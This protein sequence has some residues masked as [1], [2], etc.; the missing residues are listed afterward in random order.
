MIA[1]YLTA[2]SVCTVLVSLWMLIMAC[3]RS[4]VGK[5][6]NVDDCG[7]RHECVG[8]CAMASVVRCENRQRDSDGTPVPNS[9]NLKGN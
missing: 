7:D 1:T 2:V 6:L 4:S 3:H 8:H 5:S 9:E